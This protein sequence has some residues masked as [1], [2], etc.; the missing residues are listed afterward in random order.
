MEWKNMRKTFIALM[1]I[2]VF[3]MGFMTGCP[4]QVP[5]KQDAAIKE[6]TNLGMSDLVK[7][8]DRGI[9]ATLTESLAADPVTKFYGIKASVSHDVVTL[10]GTVK[11]EDQKKHA[12]EIVRSTG[13]ERIKEVIN[14]IVVDPNASELPF[15]W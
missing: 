14:D 11:T 1:I 12:E 3:I 9:E 15:D 4:I 8:K 5:P 7:A 2:T 6:K 13:L 10:M